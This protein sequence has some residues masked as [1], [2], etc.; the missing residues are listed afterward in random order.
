MSEVKEFKKG[1]GRAHNQPEDKRPRSYRLRMIFWFFAALFLLPA[2]VLK[3]SFHLMQIEQVI[4]GVNGNTSAQAIELR[5]RAGGQ[6]FLHSDAGGG[7][8]PAK[9]V[10]LDASGQNPILLISF[11]NDVAIGNLGSTVLVTTANFAN[12]TSSPLV[13]DFTLTN[14][15][16]ASYLAAGQLDYEAANG[17]ILWSI[18]FGDGGFT[19]SIPAGSFN[20]S[21]GNPFSGPLPSS[22]TR[23]LLFQGAASASSSNNATD[24]TLTS[25]SA[26]FTNNAGQ[27]F[28]V[29]PEPTA[30]AFLLFSAAAASCLLAFS[31]LRRYLTI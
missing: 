1:M 9:L 8:G 20:G 7:N 17:A 2:P 3:A 22:T 23:R 27:N 5:M 19:G 29:V 26:I 10:A 25:G 30:T 14:S 21:Y 6:N 16:P 18:S 28:S 24:Y 12:F 15:I 31:T 11:P 13:S 4:A